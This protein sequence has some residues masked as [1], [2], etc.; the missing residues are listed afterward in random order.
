MQLL[1][2]TIRDNN[3]IKNSESSSKGKARGGGIF[4]K[5]KHMI[6]SPSFPQHSLYRRRLFATSSLA[7]LAKKLVAGVDCEVTATQATGVASTIL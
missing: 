4:Q 7:S 5:R 3:I 6:L 2:I 1:R